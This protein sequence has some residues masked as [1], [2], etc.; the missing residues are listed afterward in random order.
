M[1]TYDAVLGPSSTQEQVYAATAQPIVESVLEG[2]NGTVFAY[3]QT[4]TGKT[5]TMDGGLD[6]RQRG[7]IPRAFDQIFA[8]IQ[9]GD[10]GASH[11]LVRASYLEIYNEDVRDLLASNPRNA[12][13]VREDAEGSV[14]AKGLHAFLVKSPAEMASVLQVGK[15]NRVVGETLM[16]RDSSRSHAIFTVTIERADQAPQGGPATGGTIRVGKLN[17]VDLAGSER[18]SATGAVG[19]RLRESARINLSL[20][21]L[22][23]VVSALVDGRTGHVPYRDSKLTRL[24]QDSL[25]GNTRTV[26][27]ACVSPAPASAGETLSTLRYA[28]R[29]KAIR[30]RPRVNED[31]KDAMIREFQEEIACLRAQLAS[32]ELPAG[33]PAAGGGAERLLPAEE[34]GAQTRSSASTRALNAQD[35][36]SR[37]AGAAV[38][39]HAAVAEAAAAAAAAQAEALTRQQ[40][41]THAER[42]KKE[43][44]ARQLRELESRMLRRDAHH[45]GRDNPRRVANLAAKEADGLKQVAEVARA[46]MAARK[47]NASLQVELEYTADA[48][49][50]QEAARVSA[51]ERAAE[52]RA[53]LLEDARRLRQ[54]LALQDLVL[55]SFVPAREVSKVLQRAHWDE[56]RESWALASPQ[57]SGSA[58]APAMHARRPSATPGALRPT[59]A[60]AR[61]AAASGAPRFLAENI[62]VLERDVPARAALGF[63]DPGAQ[64]ALDALFEWREDEP[65]L[66]LPEGRAA[67][68]GLDAP[69]WGALPRASY[70]A[71]PQSARGR[72]RSGSEFGARR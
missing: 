61:A 44:L 38:G 3:G 33:D 67:F 27:L 9:G 13:D 31:P 24:L 14:Y 16:N 12:L 22:G 62:L 72:P 18:Q 40:A 70:E 63:D 36:G 34:M 49:R 64:A 56:E 25:G 51:E 41:E 4:G 50:S 46:H 47:I 10:C 11:F 39:Q 7:V 57:A 23:N 42:A 15:R 30:N 29:A 58:D 17:L 65:R 45:S 60:W 35:G 68:A 2:Y 21:A 26:M 48:L 52:E 55:A 19:E 53:A 54:Q 59:C 5:F 69:A 71:R 32:A 37:L 66:E 8:F 43:E 1:Y 28:H 20:S 6:P